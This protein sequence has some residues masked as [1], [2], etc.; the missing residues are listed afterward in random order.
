MIDVDEYIKNAPKEA[1][2]KLRE[3]R[4]LIKELAPEA[5]EK[6]SYRMPSFKLNGKY[7]VYFAAFKNHIGFYPFPSGIEEFKKEILQYK[8]A[9]GSIQF[10]LDQPLPV[11][12]IRKIVK[13]RI[14]ENLE[15]KKGGKV[16]GRTK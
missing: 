15:R 7:L 14:K 13:F 6:I 10:P 4:E 9:K 3:I 2:E 8:S 16:Y 5:E 1:Q 12:L 11:S